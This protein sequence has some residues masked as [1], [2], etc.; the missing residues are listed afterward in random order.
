MEDIHSLIDAQKSY[1]RTGATLPASF[2]LEALRRLGDAIRSR[3]ADIAAA[4]QADLNKSA[5][6]SYMTETG[7]VLDE[8]RFVSKHL[9]RWAKPSRVPTPL[10]QFPA[11]S[12]VHKDP[13]GVVLI[14]SPWNYP[15]QLTIEPLIGALA[16]GNCAV[17][18]PSNYAPHTA[19]LIADLI[20]S[21]FPSEYVAVVQGGRAENAALLEQEFDYIFFTG[22]VQVGKLVM[23]K[24][25]AHLTPVSLELGGKSPCI[26][27]E[28]AD[29]PLAAKRL[30]FGKFLNAG[31]TCVAPDYLLVQRKVK[32]QIVAALKESIASF[33]G[34]DPLQDHDYP[35]IINDKHFERLCALLAD[36]HILEG[37][38][39]RD[40]AFIA[41]TLI[42][43][44]TSASPCMQEEIF[45]PI[46]PILEYDDLE[47]AIAFVR[48]RPKPLALYL[49]TRDKAAEK[50]VLSTLSFGGGC[51]NDTIIHLATS[52]MGFGGVGGSG[53]GSYHGKKSFD[54]FTHEKSIVKKS[55]LIDLPM[56]YHPYTEKHFRLIKRFMK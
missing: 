44:V 53:M 37:G 51:V 43:S 30:A 1:F 20:A 48:S 40:G 7:M 10:A 24:A 28:T 36:E 3:E 25:A 27:D 41:P 56:R 15:F 9:T 32:E 38:G 52:H 19:R 23:E 6:E 45:G 50:R 42:D 16:A 47:E 54:T 12:R 55:L 35:R 33:F 22:G 5:F 39:T 46:L 2:R 26:I 17:L 8:L 29:I 11:R 49:F 4:L 14:M 13:Y 18:K 21:C 31:Q 34:A